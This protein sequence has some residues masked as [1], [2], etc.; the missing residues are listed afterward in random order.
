MEDTS[1]LRENCLAGGERSQRMWLT[2]RDDVANSVG[3]SFVVEVDREIGG[4]LRHDDIV[5][6]NGGWKIRGTRNQ[7]AGYKKAVAELDNEESGFESRARLPAS[8]VV[9]PQDSEQEGLH[10]GRVNLK[11]AFL[12]ASK[13]SIHGNHIGISHQLQVMCGQG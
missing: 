2:S 4:S 12:P 9:A 10:R 1:G 8:I 13:S 11:S 6:R 3:V 5:T 7:L